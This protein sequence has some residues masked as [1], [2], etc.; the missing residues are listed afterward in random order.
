MNRPLLF[1]ALGAGGYLAYRSLKPRYEYRGRHVLVTGGSRGLG[2]VLA[3]HLVAAGARVTIC[4]RDADEL[5]RAGEHLAGRGGDV[6]TVVCDVT[7]PD[8]LTRLV[9]QARRINGPIDVLINN[10]G[11]IRVGPAEEMREEDYR[12]SLNTHFW[13]VWHLCE[14]VVPEMK[15]RRAGRIV[16]IASFGGKVAVPHL[17]PYST[18]KF[19]LVGFS[20]G[21]RAELADYGV[22]VTTVCPGLMRTG[23]HLHAEFKGRNEDEYAWFALGNGLPGFSMGADVA[24][25]KILAACS[26]GDAEA[27]LGLPAKLGV[28]AQ[29][30]FPNLTARLMAVVD[31]AVMPGPG[32]IGSKAVTGLES[33][34]TLPSAFT[35]VTDRAA[36]ANNETAVAPT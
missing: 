16:N 15:A 29:A 8:Q 13:A 31:R 17:L 7:E 9:G 25:R 5:D 12:D 26:R 30:A 11:M 1:A 32:G 6:V 18:G 21:L 22:V 34:G 4:A 27:V 2:L 20:T 14:R 3:R 23:S 35:A 28:M 24:A 19:A 36:V 10:A 33:R